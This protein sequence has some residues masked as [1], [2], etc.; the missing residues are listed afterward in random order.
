MRLNEAP[1]LTDADSRNRF[2]S[3]GLE[4]RFNLSS[5]LPFIDAVTFSYRPQAQELAGTF[6]PLTAC[7]RRRKKS[8]F[9][10]G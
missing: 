5:T 7:A 8:R 4:V 9:A 6:P 1:G 2:L 3:Y 10:A